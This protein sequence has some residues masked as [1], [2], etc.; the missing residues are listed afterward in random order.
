MSS[1][2]IQRAELA[3]GQT[4]LTLANNLAVRRTLESAGVEFTDGDQRA[5]KLAKPT[6]LSSRTN[7]AT[8]QKKQ[9]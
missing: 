7:Q 5:V 6:A 1:R 3:E 8:K 4:S 9:K 2:T